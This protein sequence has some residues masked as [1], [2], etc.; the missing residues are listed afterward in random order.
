MNNIKEEV[1]QIISKA[2]E[3]D[4][5]SIDSSVS[6]T[7]EWDSLVHLSILVS[8]DKRFDG[9]VAGIKEMA[10]VDSVRSVLKIL[11]DNNLI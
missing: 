6:N 11:K 7:E 5:I 1:V 9:G 8:L 2:L 4:K 3:V 10:A